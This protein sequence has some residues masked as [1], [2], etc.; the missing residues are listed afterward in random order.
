MPLFLWKKSYELKIPEID[1][2]HRRL[3]GL[4]NE[5]SDAMMIRK[6][7]RTIPHILD[8]LAEYVVLHFASEEK[9]MKEFNYP[10][11]DEHVR[12]H[13]EFTKRVTVYM[14]LYDQDRELNPK[15]LLDFLCDWLRNHI[16]VN[17]KAIAKHIRRVE[18]G[19]G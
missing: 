7:Q 19:L 2:Q 16:T 11:I 9:V 1:M 15:E 4:I 3:V 17:D 12:E 10:G 8:E 6:G 13:R 18:M 5:L 14:Q